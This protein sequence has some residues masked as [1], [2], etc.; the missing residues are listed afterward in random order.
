RRDRELQMLHITFG[1]H[2]QQLPLTLCDQLYYLT[3]NLS[4]HIYYKFFNRFTLLSVD[5]LNNDLGLPYLQFVALTTH[6]LDQYG[7][8]EYATT[9]DQ[10]GIRGVCRHHT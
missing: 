1:F 9:I 4:R 8:M 7:Q 3:R 5:F 10:P 2:D 6:G